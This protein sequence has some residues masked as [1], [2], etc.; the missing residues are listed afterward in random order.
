M[1]Q[2]GST[3]LYDFIALSS[4][5]IS[6]CQS[7]SEANN[8]MHLIWHHLFRCSME[9][10]GILSLCF[11]LSIS[12]QNTFV[13]LPPQKTNFTSQKDISSSFFYPHFF[14]NWNDLRKEKNDLKKK[15]SHRRR[16]DLSTFL[17]IW[18]SKSIS[19]CAQYVTL[20]SKIK[21]LSLAVFFWQP[22]KL[23]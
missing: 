22:Q 21:C 13:N 12:P 16:V 3:S 15:I 14:I 19:N 18:L 10:L 2:L 9:I 5:I 20:D 23:N 17:H 1:A 4:S 6:Q 11:L 8:S 7:I